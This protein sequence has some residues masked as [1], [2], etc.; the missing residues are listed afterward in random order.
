MPTRPAAAPALLALALLMTLAPAG[1]A[2]TARPQPRLTY[3]LPAGGRVGST[4]EVTVG[5][6]ALDAADGLWFSHPGIAA[7]RVAGKARAFKVTV[8]PGTPLGAHD[9]RALTPDGLSN[10]RTFVVG[11]LPELSEA[12]PNNAPSEANPIPINAVVN[13]STG[14]A[15]VDGFAIMGR[16]G[17]RIFA[18]LAAER[19]DSPLDATVRLL[20]ARGV[21]LA[22]SR[23]A[24]GADPFVDVTL[25]ADGRYLLKVHDVT[26]AG[27]AAHVYR[28]T[29]RDGP[30]LDAALPPIAPPG[31][32]ADLT[33]V[34]R[35][36]GG[37]PLPLRIDGRPIEG[38]TWS[39]LPSPVAAPGLPVNL[40]GT[41][42]ALRATTIRVGPD[43]NPS[44]PLLVAEA[45]GP[46]L[47][48]REPNGPGEAQAIAPPCS[49]GAAFGRKG[50]L[51]VYRFA[52]KRGEAWR[53]EAVAEGIGSMADPTL[54]VQRVPA[55]GEPEDLASADDTP[56]PGLAPRFNLATVDAGLRWTAPADG[57]YQILLSD[58]AS[59]SRGD[60]RLAYRLTLRRDRP[61]FRLF[62]VPQ[63]INVLDAT[64]VR[65]GGRAG[66]VVLA[67]RLDGFAAPILVRAEGLPAGVR[68]DPVVIPAGAVSAPIILEADPSARPSAGVVQFVGMDLAKDLTTAWDEFATGPETD[69]LRAAIP[70]SILRPPPTIQGT[71]VRVTPARAT[72]G[73][74]VAV[75]AGAPFL[76]TARPRRPVVVQGGSI[77]FDLTVRPGPGFDDAIAV[78][79]W[80]PP[81]AMPAPSATIPKGSTSARVSWPVPKGLAP[82]LHTLALK[83]S[84]AYPPDP[85]G[86]AKFKVEEP[87][88]AVV[89]A[90]VPTPLAI[91]V[92]GKI[93]ALKAGES[94]DVAIKVE[95]QGGFSGP[96][97]LA[98]GV[99]ESAKVRAEP[100]T[101]GADKV[102]ASLV[103]RAD[104]EA[105][106]GPVASAVIRAEAVILGQTIEVASP[107]S[108]TLTKP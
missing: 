54:V 27:S 93:P 87:S 65:A 63:A 39:G 15:D 105:P 67:Q 61:D 71:A 16:Q 11:A 26:Y 50:D 82:G 9:V 95:R 52:A 100:V 24:L 99:P 51:D 68:C 86:K 17:Q 59:S 78:S 108:L 36:L 22:E 70:G 2:Q 103:L 19:I 20:D 72:R 1:R 14:P 13:G 96:V 77:E 35:N 88:N 4:A 106:A 43:G 55:A 49:V 102:T 62:V 33:L 81:A 83:G 92:I 66:A 45:D 41:A 75:R 12:E 47:A 84:A 28:L 23:D 38:M 79:A 31:A 97:P 80:E 40:L 60:P 7:E 56:D 42:A 21:E 85:K 57:T 94:A 6:E 32:M 44:N 104:K 37:K 18:N 10:P 48:E 69:R 3:V 58:A 64:T 107:L 46:V 101:L 5:G 8:K 73:F 34:G 91:S 53:I 89:V 90:V 74:A 25:P 98:L 30:Y 29:V 76:L